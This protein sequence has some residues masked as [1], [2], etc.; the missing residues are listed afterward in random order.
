[1]DLDTKQAGDAKS[2]NE[3]GGEKE[4]EEKNTEKDG[5][6]AKRKR[7]V[8]ESDGEEGE[9]VEEEES[10]DETDGSE[11]GG[12]ED[13][14]VCMYGKSFRLFLRLRSVGQTRGIV[15]CEKEAEETAD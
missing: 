4:T 13:L 10:A 1:M 7:E 8:D 9:K 12:F 15:T 14:K 6:Q 11:L 2:D 5:E 3:E